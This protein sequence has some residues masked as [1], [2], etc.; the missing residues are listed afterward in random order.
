M[1]FRLKTIAGIAFIEVI[2]LGFLVFSSMEYLQSSNEKQLIERAETSAKLFATMT[3]DAIV[4]F[5]LASLDELSSKVISN[6]DILYIRVRNVE[7][8]VLSEKG[9]DR[10]LSREFREDATIKQASDDKIFDVSQAVTL[11][12]D[13]IGYV[14]LGVST[15]RLEVVF[16]KAAQ[17]MFTVASIEVILV[18]VFGFILGGILTKQLT[19]LQIGARAIAD[20]DLGHTIVVS[21]MDELADTAECF[22]EMSTA[23]LNYEQELKLERDKADQKRRLAESILGDAVESLSQGILIADG[24]DNVVHMNQAYIDIYEISDDKLPAGATTQDVCDLVTATKDKSYEHQSEDDGDA[25]P[26]MR[27]SNDRY[28]MQSYKALS[29]GGHVWLETDITS[30][31]KAEK[32]TRQLEHELLQAQ[33]ME[34][35]GTLA[36]GIAH[37]INTPIQYIGDNL[38]FIGDSATDMLDFFNKYDALKRDLFEKDIQLETIKQCED[39]FEEA[40]IDFLLEELPSAIDQSQQGVKHVSNIVLAMKEF[41]H[42]TSKDK[43]TADLNRIIERCV[44][45]CKSEWGPVAEL[46]LKL[47]ENLPSVMGYESDLN[48]VIL[49]LVVNAA[50]ALEGKTDGTGRIEITTETASD[51]VVVKVSDN[52]CGIPKEGLK[53][54]FE[55]FYT[56]KEV[57]K[58]TGQGLAITHD[59]IA[60][61]HEGEIKVESEVGV[62]TVFKIILSL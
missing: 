32:K 35:I 59:I 23:L 15:H 56:T 3:T 27:L 33:K 60:R 51:N 17:H 24:N 55:P 49:N 34:S 45:V 26:I 10:I 12:A 38:R 37:E 29:A 22:N 21:G 39:A 50:H 2:L 41:A 31:I 40:D 52:G 9:E 53:R 25:L 61:K 11:D 13:K 44:T 19:S 57:G 28:V 47:D 5:D 46:D 30:I 4:A 62:G 42:P 14:E 58:G 8:Q 43:N 18:G 16:D 7:G 20:G 1:S 54:I 36:G 6:P 48:Q